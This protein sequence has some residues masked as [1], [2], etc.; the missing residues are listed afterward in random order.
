VTSRFHEKN[1]NCRSELGQI[2]LDYTPHDLEIHTEVVVADFVAHPSNLLPR[3][4]RRALRCLCGK[5]LGRLSD[6]FQCSERGVLAHPVAEEGIVVVAAVR[7][8]VLDGVPNVLE[9]DAIASHSAA[10]SARIRFCKYGLRP[11]VRQDVNRTAEEFFE[12]LFESD[13]VE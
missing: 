6:D 7:G 4:F 13:H 1:G 12:I 2:L 11:P 3:D 9:I 10:A 5:I 8:D